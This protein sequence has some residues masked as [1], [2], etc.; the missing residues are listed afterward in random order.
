[1][2]DRRSVSKVMVLVL[3]LLMPVGAFAL[4]VAWETSPRLKRRE[5]YKSQSRFKSRGRS[6]KLLNS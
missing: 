2:W 6:S 1:V 5:R 3:V 4:W